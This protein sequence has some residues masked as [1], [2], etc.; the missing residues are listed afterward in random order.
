ME[1]GQNVEANANIH[2]HGNN[3]ELNV[4]IINN[5]IKIDVEDE[6]NNQRWAACL[7]ANYIEE[8]TL[9]T[10]NFKRFHTFSKM[11]LSALTTQSD[12]V[13]IDL[14]SYKDLVSIVFVDVEM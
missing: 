9:K 5:V 1:N 7:D 8:I 6:G 3:Y 12:T 10:G 4:S 14:L 2:L 11:L 13:F